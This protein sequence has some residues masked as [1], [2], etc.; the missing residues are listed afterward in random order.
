MRR[1]ILGLWMLGDMK[2]VLDGG[3][4]A[5]M[6]VDDERSKASSLGP[7]WMRRLRPPGLLRKRRR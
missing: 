2:G 4:R 3:G 5:L 6:H 7:K 1:T